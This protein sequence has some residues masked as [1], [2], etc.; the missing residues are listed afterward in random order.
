MAKSQFLQRSIARGLLLATVMLALP[1]RATAESLC[2]AAV[3]DRLIQHRVAPDETL[4]QIARRYRLIPATIMGFNP[5][6]RN[7]AAAVGTTL[8]IPP[9]NGIQVNVPAGTDLKALAAKY[10]VRADVLF[11]LNGCQPN[12]RVAFI[13]G[14]NWSPVGDNGSRAA[15][16]SRPAIAFQYPLAQRAPILMAYGWK[17]RTAPMESQVALH[18]GVDL[19]ALTG[20]AVRAA[21]AG[22]VAF[23]GEKDSYGQLVVINHAQGYQT[24]YAQLATLQV[25]LGQTVSAGQA[26]ATVG[27]TGQPSSPEPHLHFELRSNSPLGWVAEDP[28]TAL[29]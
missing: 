17:L 20:D 5:S 4:D 12:P 26:I 1:S 11:E 7:G 23:V 27:Q 28:A 29:K 25:R 13:P 14:A 15:A 3:L 22:T 16:I 24:R 8:T 2:S 18:S 6:T 9:F 10:K 21:A 19:A